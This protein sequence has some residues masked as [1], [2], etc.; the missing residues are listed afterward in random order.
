[1]PDIRTI[2]L[3]PQGFWGTADHGRLIHWVRRKEGEQDGYFK[4]KCGMWVT[5]LT[6]NPEGEKCKRCCK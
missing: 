4:A 6:R 5:G 2:H 1:M 3:I